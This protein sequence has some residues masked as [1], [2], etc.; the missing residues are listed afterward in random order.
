MVFKHANRGRNTPERVLSSAL[1]D[2]GIL[3]AS[4][5]MLKSSVDASVATSDRIFAPVQQVAVTKTTLLNAQAI[6]GVTEE[7]RRIFN[8]DT[9]NI[10]TEFNALLT[11]MDSF[12]TWAE[13]NYPV[14]ASSRLEVFEF[15]GDGSGNVQGYIIPQTGQLGTRL[16]GIIDAIEA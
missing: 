15:V 9:Y 16:Q 12:S 3:R 4:A 13:A 6:A 11:A 14:S 7:A 1:S 5:V 10:G 2:V 8:D